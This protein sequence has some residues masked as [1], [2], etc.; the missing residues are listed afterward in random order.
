[1]TSPVHAQAVVLAGGRSSRLGGTPKALLRAVETGPTLVES[2]VGDLVAAGLNTD[3]V[4]VVGPP[5]L[6]PM[7]ALRTREEPPFA[8]PAAGIVAG[9]RALQAAGGTAPW[10]LLLACDMPRVGQAITA[11]L[12]AAQEAQPDVRGIVVVDDGRLQPLAAIYRS[13]ALLETVTDQPSVN[14]SV[15]SLVGTLWDRQLTLTGA[16]DDVDTWDD[17]ERFGLRPP[18]D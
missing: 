6:P 17:V 3:D 13:A 8:G 14:R 18:Q 2:T 10:T 5:E 15:R 11:L 1:M 9:L 4:V 7:P 12:G 16:T